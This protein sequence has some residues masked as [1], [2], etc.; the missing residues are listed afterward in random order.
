[1]SKKIG[2]QNEKEAKS[3]A[4][5]GIFFAISIGIIIACLSWIFIIPLSKLL[6]GNASDDWLKLTVIY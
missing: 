3:L 2:E 5:I 4:S 1:M 6:S